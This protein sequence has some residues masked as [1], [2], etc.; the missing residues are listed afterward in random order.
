[1]T[2]K[3]RI[4]KGL[5]VFAEEKKKLSE[6]TKR[7]LESRDNGCAALAEL[8][9]EFIGNY[10]YVSELAKNAEEIKLETELEFK[11]K[12]ANE[13]VSLRAVGEKGEMVNIKAFLKSA[14]EEL[15]A[16]SAAIFERTWRNLK[17]SY[18][19]YIDAI[20]QRI[21]FTKSEEFNSRNT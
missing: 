19:K 16:N 17:E 6:L 10:V 7:Y 8:K 5:S 1:M 20:I 13:W 3:E 11:K 4:S 21:S 12:K 18:Q 14:D 15:T 9:D 2:H